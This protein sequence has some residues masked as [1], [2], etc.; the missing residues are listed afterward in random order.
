MFESVRAAAGSF[1]FPAWCEVSFI[2]HW[3]WEWDGP[4]LLL[5]VKWD[6]RPL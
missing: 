5:L 3:E 4:Q 2:P 1:D 6:R